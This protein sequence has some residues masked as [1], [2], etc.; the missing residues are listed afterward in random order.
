VH[1]P[2]WFQAIDTDRSN[3]LSADELQRAL[4]LGGLNFSITDVDQMVR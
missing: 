3:S 1:N 4:A 2:Q